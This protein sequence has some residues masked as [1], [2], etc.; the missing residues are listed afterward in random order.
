MYTSHFG[1]I[2]KPFS[3]SPDPDYLYFSPRHKKALTILEYGLMSQAG[4]TVITGEIGSGK[5][6]L[7]HHILNNIDDEFI[8]GLIA[9]KGVLKDI[10]VI[11]P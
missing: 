9:K 1:L 6:T 3:L 11:I 5:T 7:I 4:F 10:A 8:V 2:K